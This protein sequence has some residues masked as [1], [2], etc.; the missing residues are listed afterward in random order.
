MEGSKREAWVRTFNWTSMTMCYGIV[1]VIAMILG[2]FWTDSYDLGSYGQICAA[3]AVSSLVIAVPFVRDW[4]KA[5]NKINFSKTLQTEFQKVLLS[6]RNQSVF[7]LKS[8]EPLKNYK[9][10]F[11]L[12]VCLYFI[13]GNLFHPLH[14][15]SQRK[16]IKQWQ[17]LSCFHSPASLKGN[18]SA[19]W[20]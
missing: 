1:I 15:L 18:L 7:G 9:L 5:Q 16:R 12:A 17:H 3:I 20:P 2:Y 8:M 19:L 11:L 10:V 14:P 13:S 4:P 6:Y